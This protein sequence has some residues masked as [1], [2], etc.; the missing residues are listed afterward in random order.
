MRYPVTPLELSE[1]LGLLPEPRAG[2]K[3]RDYLR[4]RYPEKPPGEKWLLDEEQA[5]DVRRHFNERAQDRA[6][7]PER[8]ATGTES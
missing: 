5:E 3:V 4:I 6:D 2:K 7:R 8:A 1:E